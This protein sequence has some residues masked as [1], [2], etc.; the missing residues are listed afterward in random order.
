M[1]LIL[2]A[3]SDDTHGGPIIVLSSSAEYSGAANREGFIIIGSRDNN[4]FTMSRHRDVRTLLSG[5][6]GTAGTNTRGV[7]LATGDLVIS[8]N[9]D[10]KGTLGV[11]ALNLQNLSLLAAN[12]YIHFNNSS[13]KIFKDGSNLKF[14]DN[15][16][17]PVTL[18]DLNSLS[19][20]D[21]TEVF[22]VSGG[23]PSYVK[24]SGS[25]SFD[26]GIL[27]SGPPRHTTAIGD[28]VYFFVSGALG[29]DGSSP[30]TR[31][32]ALFGGDVHVSGTLRAEMPFYLSSLNHAYSTGPQGSAYG[33]LSPGAGAIINT[34]D[35]QFPPVQIKGT[36]NNKVVLG[37]S[38]S[39]D[40]VTGSVS[41]G[42]S[43]IKMV[44]DVTL[45]FHNSAGEVFRLAAG[46]SGTNARFENNNQLRFQDDSR[47][48]YGLTE[49]SVK[50]LRLHNNS[51]GG[52][53]V[54]STTSGRMEVTGSIYPGADNTYDLGSPSF[55]WANV[56][57]GDLHLRNDRGNW[58]IYE[59]PDMLVVV[60][61]LT[62]K[63]YKMGLTP[64]EDQD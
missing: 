20:T 40:F 48:I 49:D 51:S 60:N 52:S 55:R 57:T 47:Y 26:T 64:L 34:Y 23:E 56:Y 24:T 3:S 58:T 35:G 11:G 1:T 14:Q 53:V 10:I 8:G 22:S 6:V 61:N 59:E 19:V 38:G 25:F 31:A 43:R 63:K 28:D 7:T 41:S 13:Y 36:T 15:N 45:G 12:P 37:L 50:K 54:V 21:N 16:T 42:A 33:T 5:A 29:S 32:T 4:L 44:S 62:G 17:G 18:T 39:L 2:S 9:A 30:V 27:S 46:S